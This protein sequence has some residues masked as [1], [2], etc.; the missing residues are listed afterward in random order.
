MKTMMSAALSFILFLSSLSY[1]LASTD[2]YED[3]WNMNLD[4][5]NKTLQLDFLQ[6]M[7][8]NSLQA[9]RYVNFTLQDINYVQE[10][11]KML[12][13]MSK[14]VS[15]PNDIRDFMTGRYTSYKKF[16]DLLLQQ[17]FLQGTPFINP[18]P[19]MKKYLAT[20][21]KTMKKDPIYFAVAL[22]PCARLWVWLAN[23]LN[24]SNTNV[25]FTWKEDNKDGHP[26]KHY[27]ALLN[28]YLNTHTKKK[29]AKDLFQKQMQNEHDFFATS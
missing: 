11:T 23:N 14:K 13:T 3:L 29:Y 25:Y 15:K 27:K 16:L 19:A 10:V 21:S 9:E 8:T 7:Q 24:I 20:Y 22:L 28:K 6:Q 4:I 18:T 1:S 17:Y 12:K 26:E 2:V 5:A